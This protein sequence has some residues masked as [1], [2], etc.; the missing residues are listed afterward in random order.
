MKFILNDENYNSF[1]YKVCPLEKAKTLYDLIRLN[2][3]K[4]FYL[5]SSSLEE[6]INEKNPLNLYFGTDENL[7]TVLEIKKNIEIKKDDEISQGDSIDNYDE[8]SQDE[9][10]DS[11]YSEDEMKEILYD[12][13]YVLNSMFEHQK[14]FLIIVIAQTI[15]FI[16]AFYSSL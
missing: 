9:S 15:L 12:I 6:K 16:I 1:E 13:N 11:I 7:I 10:D 14:L 3:Y 4:D 2:E 5:Y 8:I